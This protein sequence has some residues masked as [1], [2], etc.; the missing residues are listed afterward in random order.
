MLGLA[1][2]LFFSVTGL[3]LNHPDWFVSES[4]QVVEARGT[5]PDDWIAPDRDAASIDRLQLVELL[6][7]R[8]G[9]RGALTDFTI[10]DSQC[11]VAFKGPGYMA[12]AF[13]DRET[14]GYQLTEARMGTVALLNDLHKGRDSGRAWSAIIDFS[15]ILLVLISV[16]GL[17]LLFYVKRRRVAGLVLALAGTLAVVLTC[18]WLVP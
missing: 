9:I 6:R 13:F 5:V 1:V 16:S 18:W 3:T 11:V 17:V 10:D 15:A 4:Q 8:H 7:S 14:G 2:T 12:D